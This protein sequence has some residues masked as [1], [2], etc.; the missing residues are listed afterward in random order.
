MYYK[1]LGQWR[2][3][4]VFVSNCVLTTKIQFLFCLPQIWGKVMV[5]AQGEMAFYHIF[6]REKLW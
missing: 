1:Y 4:I 3:D 2:F 5:K 6:I